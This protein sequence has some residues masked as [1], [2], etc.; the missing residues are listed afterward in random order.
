LIQ[1][2]FDPKNGFGFLTFDASFEDVFVGATELMRFG[3]L[4][5]GK[6]VSFRVVERNGL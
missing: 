5:T 2:W 1:K 6:R 3:S 4:G